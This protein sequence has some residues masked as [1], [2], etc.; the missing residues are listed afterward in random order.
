[1]STLVPVPPVR[2]PASREYSSTRPSRPPA[3]QP[4]S[5]GVLPGVVSPNPPM[6]LL[7]PANQSRRT[8][9]RTASEVYFV[10]LFAP[11][12]PPSL[13]LK[14]AISPSL[15]RQPCP[16]ARVMAPDRRCAGLLRF[17]FHSRCIVGGFVEEDGACNTHPPACHEYSITPSSPARMPG[18]QPVGTG[19]SLLRYRFWAC[20]AMARLPWASG[21]IVPGTVGPR[22]QVP[23]TGR[24]CTERCAAVPDWPRCTGISSLRSTIRRP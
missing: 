24:S 13:H 5:S 23:T 15:P 7:A 6:P 22:S 9:E 17:R 4:A 16:S 14:A 1:M 12:R 8:S 10:C 18:H 19:P 3:R 11:A 2:Q 20:F 21:T